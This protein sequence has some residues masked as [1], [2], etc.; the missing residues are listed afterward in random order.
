[1]SC[2]EHAVLWGDDGLLVMSPARPAPLNLHAYEIGTG[3]PIDLDEV[4]TALKDKVIVDAV[5]RADGSAWILPVDAIFGGLLVMSTDNAGSLR[6]LT[7]DGDVFEL[8]ELRTVAWWYKRSRSY[9]SSTLTASDGT[10]WLAPYNGGVLACKDSAF[11]RYRVEADDVDDNLLGS[12]PPKADP[13]NFLAEGKDGTIYA[14]SSSKVFAL[15]P[16][17]KAA[18]AQ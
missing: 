6:V 8:D 17:H 15:P 11:I 16:A 5:R 1:M 18:G 9:P 3:K 7:P 12:D 2:A 14:A 4:K 13:V 10:F